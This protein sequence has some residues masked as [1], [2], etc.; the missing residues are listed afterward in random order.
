MLKA[1]VFSLVFFI[2][3]WGSVGTRDARAG[4]FPGQYTVEQYQNY[5]EE[6]VNPAAGVRLHKLQGAKAYVDFVNKEGGAD[7][8]YPFAIYYFT[9]EINNNAVVHWVDRDGC[10]LYATE[11]DLKNIATFIKNGT[12]L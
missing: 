7:Y 11:V 9:N 5:I 10:I 2:G 6:T 4:C 12:T 3:G 1:L 8:K